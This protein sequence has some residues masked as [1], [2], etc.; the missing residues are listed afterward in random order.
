MITEE[1]YMPT[2]QNKQQKQTDFFLL[3][4][5]KTQTIILLTLITFLCAGGCLFYYTIFPEQGRDASLYVR[6]I[7][8]WHKGGFEEVL[9]NWPVGFTFWIPPLYFYISQFF[10]G[11]GLSAEA[12]GVLVSML[13]GIAVPAIVYGIAYEVTQKKN[14]A[15]AA[16]LLTAVNPVLIELACTVQRDMPYFC[17][18]SLACYFFC[19]GIRRGKWYFYFSSGLIFAFSF[20]T[21]YETLELLPLFFFYFLIACILKYDK[22]KNLLRNGV[23]F[24][25]GIILS[26][27]MLLWAMDSA[28]STMTKMYKFYFTHKYT[29]WKSLYFTQEKQDEPVKTTIPATGNNLPKTEEKK[30]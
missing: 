21:R 28:N 22:W 5:S 20:L 26:G 4:D 8:Q 15:I 1:M 29:L 17:F 7:A 6:F 14:I 27:M 18:C 25:I 10:M 12:A 19:A 13:C 16:A 11:L 24:L 2:E 23:L 9:R 30:K 3:I